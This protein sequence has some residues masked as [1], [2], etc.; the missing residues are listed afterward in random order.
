MPRLLATHTHPSSWQA[1]EP[2]WLA[3]NQWGTGWGEDGYV[4]ISTATSGGG[5]TAQGVCG[6]LMDASI[7][8][9]VYMYCCVYG[10]SK[11]S[12]EQ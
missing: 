6:I 8:L 7:P 9:Q 11:H 2:Y 4:R 1:S 5:V 3:K 12:R 10:H